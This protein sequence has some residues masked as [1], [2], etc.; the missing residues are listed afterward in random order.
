MT[1]DSDFAVSIAGVNG[2]E[3]QGEGA[4]VCLMRSDNREWIKV[5]LPYRE[6]V[7]LADMLY[8]ITREHP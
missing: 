2:W 6:A 1:A 3:S 5:M 4:V 8:M 7:Q